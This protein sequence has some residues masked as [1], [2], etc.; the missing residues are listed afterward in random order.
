[1]SDVIISSQIIIIIKVR[2]QL[3]I[4]QRCRQTAARYFIF[5][6]DIQYLS[7]HT[8]IVTGAKK[9]V[10]LFNCVWKCNID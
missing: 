4:R 6:A 5:V 8:K 2:I 3:E 1:M 9:Y 7:F 10:L